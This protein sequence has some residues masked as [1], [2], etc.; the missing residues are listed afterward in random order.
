MYF[1]KSAI[2][3]EAEV[4]MILCSSI[5]AIG[6][7]SQ[8]FLESIADCGAHEKQTVQPAEGQETPCRIE[9]LGKDSFLRFRDKWVM[10]RARNILR[11]ASASFNACSEDAASITALNEFYRW[12][13]F[14]GVKADRDGKQ[15]EIGKIQGPHDSGSYPENMAAAGNRYMRGSVCR[16]KV[17]RVFRKPCC[18]RA[19]SQA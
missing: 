5:Q 18:Q 9:D 3:T 13:A 11:G 4:S 15:L 16:E 12:R 17:R 2:T 8:E 10:N 1:R 14:D 7:N 19:R 6:R